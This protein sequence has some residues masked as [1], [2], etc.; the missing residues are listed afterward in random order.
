MEI[1]GGAVKENNRRSRVPMCLSLKCASLIVLH[2]FHK[3][4]SRR[5]HRVPMF[6]HNFC[7]SWLMKNMNSV[8]DLA[9]R[10]L[11]SSIGSGRMDPKLSI[12]S[13]MLYSVQDLAGRI[14]HSSLGSGRLYPIL[15]IP[16]G[17]SFREIDTSY[18]SESMWRKVFQN[19]HWIVYFL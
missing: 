2:Y 4:H 12:P 7:C 1:W 11:Q 9:G 10:I 19:K 15:S 8:Q 5:R 18:Y 16:V 3:L 13:S 17:Y 6:F 14:L